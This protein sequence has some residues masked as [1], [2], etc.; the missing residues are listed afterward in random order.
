MS[1]SSSMTRANVA[2]VAAPALIAVAGYFAQ[3]Y[4]VSGG[5]EKGDI[6]D[7]EAAER[8]IQ[9]RRSIFP[10]DYDTSRK[11]PKEIIHKMLINANYAPT[12]GRTKPWRFIVFGGESSLKALGEFE[13]GL[14][15][16]L[17]PADQFKQAKYEKKLTNKTKSSFV[18]AIVMARQ[19]SEKI[20]EIEEIEAVACAVQNM[21]LIA[22][23]HGV[24][25]YWS[26]GNLVYSQEYKDFLGVENEKDKVLG[27]FHIGYPSK[28]WPT[29]S[30]TDIDQKV[31]WK[32]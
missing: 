8:I 16:K 11:V 32:L 9:K 27:M 30:R 29:E 2:L 31:T 3:R 10:R 12:H 18:I 20:P 7:R 4:W 24:G 14:Y 22:S 28:A 15:K 1:F 25:A 6:D 17:T 5:K 21:H 13:A 19:K 23:A 26:S